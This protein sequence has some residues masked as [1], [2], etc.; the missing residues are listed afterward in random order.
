MENIADSSG[1]F[2]SKVLEYSISLAILLLIVTGLSVSLFIVIKRN[3]KLTDEAMKREVNHHKHLQ[4]IY[5]KAREDNE[6][7][8]KEVVIK[9]TDL[10]NITMQT[11]TR[12][13]TFLDMFMLTVVQ[14]RQ[15]FTQATNPS[16]P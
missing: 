16:T 7:V 2:L 5:D 1:Q 9:I 3:Q 15:H 13:Q 10:T 14:Q 4:L 11:I 8:Q 12:T 6:R